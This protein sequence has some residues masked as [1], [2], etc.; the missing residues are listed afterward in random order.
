VSDFGAVMDVLISECRTAVP[1]IP[2]GALGAE[3]DFR[4][5]EEL[6]KD[7]LPHVFVHSPA[8]Q[9]ELLDLQQERRTFVC[10]ID[11]WDEVG[12]EAMAVYLDA[13]RDRIAANRTLT[14]SVDYATVSARQIVELA[15]KT[16]RVGRLEV[17]AVEDV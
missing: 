7:E 4:L 5:G 1:A 15:G 8:E 6:R 17:T 2:A 16:R 3:R 14:S 10:T 11:V 13:I 9:I 12:Q